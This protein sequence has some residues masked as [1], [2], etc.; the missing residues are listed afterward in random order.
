ME[1]Q[2]F[3]D[4]EEQVNEGFQIDNDQ[5]A[6]WALRKI[7]Q[8]Q[9]QIKNNNELAQA[10]IEKIEAWNQQENDKAQQSIDYFQGLLAHYAMKKRE[11]DPK[12]KSQKLPH[13]N[14]GFRKKPAKWNYDD[15]ALLETL[16]TNNLTDHINVTEKPNKS[17]IKKSFEVVDGKVIDS[18]TGVV[19]EGITV[20]E[21]GEDFT[22]KVSD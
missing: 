21:Q 6:N 17:S 15:V 14:I 22:V 18:E 19:I 3:L 2:E 1:L 8:H 12:F 5:T 10:E 11:E 20:E 16:K 7:K 9:Q 13:G 4:Q